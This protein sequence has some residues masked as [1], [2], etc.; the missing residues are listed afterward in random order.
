MS[1]EEAVNAAVHG[2]ARKKV[3]I[4]NH[5][6]NV[7]W[8]SWTTNDLDVEVTGKLD[9]HIPNV[10]DDHVRYKIHMRVGDPPQTV[11]TKEVEHG[12]V[13][14]IL[15]PILGAGA[16]AALAIFGGPASPASPLVGTATEELVRRLG[17]ALG[18][19]SWEA[20]CDAILNAIAVA[21]YRI[22]AGLEGG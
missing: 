10:G 3:R 13:S 14:H 17:D 5:E 4:K 12:G 22:E 20:E 15:A 1:L 7:G 19:S 18:D 21:I 2:P 8:A 6:F 11:V 16:A 9:H